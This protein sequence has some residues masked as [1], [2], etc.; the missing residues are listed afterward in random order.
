[1]AMVLLISL[2]YNNYTRKSHE[3]GLITKKYTPMY[4][5]SNAHKLILRLNFILQCLSDKK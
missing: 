5:S 2:L 1:M 4:V 3:Q